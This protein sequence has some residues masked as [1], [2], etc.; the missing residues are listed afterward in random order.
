MILQ[1]VLFN[2]SLH[3]ASPT[4][5]VNAFFYRK[6]EITTILLVRLNNLSQIMK[7][8]SGRAEMKSGR[9]AHAS[10][11]LITLL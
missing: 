7:L 9:L 6:Y 10:L 4:T 8:I 5:W 11:P 3:V 2:P 1:E